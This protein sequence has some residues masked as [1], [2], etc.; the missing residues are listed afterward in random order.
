MGIALFDRGARSVTLT[1]MGQAYLPS[2]R[3]AFDELAVSTSG[4]FAPA[5]RD[6]LTVRVPISYVTTWLAPPPGLR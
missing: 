4:L 5:R 2:V 6:Q 1:E 3:T